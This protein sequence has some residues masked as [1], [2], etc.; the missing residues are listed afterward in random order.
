MAMIAGYNIVITYGG[1]Q[2]IG[3]TQDDLN[4]SAITKESITKD[5]AGVKQVAVTGHDVTFSVTAILESGASQ[6]QMDRD[7]I[8]A[9]ALATGSG[10][11]VALVYSAT[12]MDNYHG[13]AII[14]SFSESSPADPES[15]TTISLDLQIVG[16]FTKVS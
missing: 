1:K 6:T 13:Q 15:D 16:A 14:T 7:D 9:L 10:A 8:L 4:I 5:D 12:G 2:L 11:E 3:V